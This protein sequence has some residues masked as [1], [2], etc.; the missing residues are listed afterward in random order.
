MRLQSRFTAF[1][2]AGSA[3]GPVSAIPSERRADGTSTATGAGPID[4]GDIAAVFVADLVH[5]ATQLGQQTE[6]GAGANCEQTQSLVI[7]VGYAKYEGYRNDTTGL[8]YWKGYGR[9]R[10]P[11][12]V[13]H[14]L[15]LQL[16]C[17]H[18]AFVM[19]RHQQGSCGGS[20]HNP[21]PNRTM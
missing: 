18:I 19:Q 4:T 13:P 17:F 12:F 21:P 6:A 15:E 3:L 20:P 10:S 2:M 11:F 9:M 1:L 16:T 8:N 7:D 14:W 5:N